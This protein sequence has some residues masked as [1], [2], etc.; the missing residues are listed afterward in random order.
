[1]NSTLGSVVPLAIFNIK[2]KVEYK[3]RWNLENLPY[4]SNVVF[5]KEKEEN[6]NIYNQSRAVKHALQF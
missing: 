3:V 5:A 1:M 2:A 6:N 4:L